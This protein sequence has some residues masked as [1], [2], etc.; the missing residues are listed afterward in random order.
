MFVYSSIAHSWSEMWLNRQ[1]DTHT[2]RPSTVTLAAHARRGL[3]IYYT[4]VMYYTSCYTDVP[5]EL[6]G[7]EYIP[8]LPTLDPSKYFMSINIVS[9]YWKTTI[10]NYTVWEQQW[11][12]CSI[13]GYLPYIGDYC[14]TV[15]HTN[16][17]LQL[18]GCFKI[19]E[20]NFTGPS[21]WKNYWNPFG[22]WWYKLLFQELK[23]QCVFSY[24]FSGGKC[25]RTTWRRD[26][27][28]RRRSN[29][30]RGR[31]GYWYMLQSS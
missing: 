4:F 15:L 23:V 7:S 21:V 19:R 2:H 28:W 6:V 25:H 1:T 18:Y 26:R 11:C 5:E 31:W 13:K 27:N 8:K 24:S 10:S 22:K 30:N 20:G 12:Y 9:D 14:Y 16:H 3:I 17:C 29:L